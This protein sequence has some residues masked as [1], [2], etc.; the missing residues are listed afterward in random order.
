MT[1]LS[2]FHQRIHLK[3]NLDLLIGDDWVP[4][5]KENSVGL[6]KCGSRTTLVAVAVF[7]DKQTEIR[8]QS[9]ILTPQRTFLQPRELYNPARDVVY[10]ILAGR[11]E[12]YINCETNIKEILTT[13]EQYKKIK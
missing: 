1:N 6:V 9:L 5:Y 7:L 2:N 10:R 8:F 12:A 3:Y 11:Y 4:S 13:V